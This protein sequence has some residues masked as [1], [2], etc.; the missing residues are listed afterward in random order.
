M[1]PLFNL[2]R[3]HGLQVGSTL[4]LKVS[5]AVTAL[6]GTPTRAPGWRI[7]DGGDTG[8]GPRQPVDDSDVQYLLTMI[9]ISVWI[10]PGVLRVQ[11]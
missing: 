6:T 5:S 10:R 9:I 3:G 1:G 8:R 7:G 2:D 4:Y 11:L